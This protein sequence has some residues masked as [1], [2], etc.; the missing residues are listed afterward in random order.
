MMLNENKWPV[1]K[2]VSL[3]W[4]NEHRRKG[5]ESSRFRELRELL[6]P[7]GVLLLFPSSASHFSSILHVKLPH[8]L[9]NLCAQPSQV[10]ALSKDN[11]P[12]IYGFSQ[13]CHLSEVYAVF[14]C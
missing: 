4:E 11:I 12:V 10:L 5:S 14:S 3:C 6:V 2:Y 8:F 13:L 7:I 9:E 1:L